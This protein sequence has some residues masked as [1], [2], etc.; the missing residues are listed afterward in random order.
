MARLSPLDL[1]GARG[2]RNRK[3]SVLT[4]AVDSFRMMKLYEGEK[5]G[6]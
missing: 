3:M 1:G 4:D 6:L 2:G 5:R